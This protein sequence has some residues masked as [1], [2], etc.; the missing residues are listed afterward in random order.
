MSIIVQV[1]VQ[2]PEDDWA[3]MIFGSGFTQYPW[4]NDVSFAREEGILSGLVL[5]PAADEDGVYIEFQVTL[6]ELADA[7][8]LLAKR[9]N[10]F[11]QALVDQDLDAGDVD[12]IMQE[13]VLGDQ[14]YG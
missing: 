11:A 5:D 4:W 3:D 6:Q 8:S 7:A 14:V 9:N 1:P 13:C 2:I 10:R 12:A